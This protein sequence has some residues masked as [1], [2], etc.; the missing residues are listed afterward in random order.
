MS[1]N[2]LTP[3]LPFILWRYPLDRPARVSKSEYLIS[4]YEMN[5]SRRCLTWAASVRL[6][7]FPPSGASRANFGPSPVRSHVADISGKASMMSWSFSD[8][9]FSRTE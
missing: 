2:F 1:S 8:D 7:I 9:I 6:V 5:L 3:M 4:W